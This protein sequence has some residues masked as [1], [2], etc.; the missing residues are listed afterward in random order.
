MIKKQGLVK[1]DP[2]D[3]EELKINVTPRQKDPIFE[4]EEKAK[5]LARLLKSRNPQDLEMANKL[6]K[7]MV[8]QV[9]LYTDIKQ[10]W[11]NSLLE[12]HCFLMAG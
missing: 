2:T 4:D 6:I 7:N 10:T 3:V 9:I 12:F 5:Q 1:E 11:L 8:K